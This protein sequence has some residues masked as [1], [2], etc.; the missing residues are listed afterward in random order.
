MFRTI[1]VPL[2]DS[3][4]AE[5]VLPWALSLA[6]RAGATLD[7]VRGHLLYALTQPSAAWAPFDP[8]AEAD[9]KQE[10]RAYLGAV[11]RRL[12]GAARV[13][14]TT[15]LVDGLEAEGILRRVREGRADL[16]V[17][18]THGRG[19]LGRFFLGSVADVLVRETSVPVLLV[20]PRGVAPDLLPGP[21]VANVLVPLDGSRLAEQVL[22]PAADLA[23]A[24]LA[25]C[26]L[27]RV[28]EP[29]GIATESA[30]LAAAR[31]AAALVYL[32]AVADRLRG[33]G[34]PVRARV[35]V[36]AH[37][38]RAILSE[39]RAL[40]GT[41]ITLAT[42]GRSGVPRLVLGSVA[43]QVIRTAPGPVLVYRPPTG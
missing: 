23:R 4:F 10:E 27:L 39:A 33:Q 24:L 38:A 25:P 13:S 9:T 30:S 8:A 17:M 16:V 36:T 3:P 12:A 22:S 18:A 40:E 29:S 11:A 37:P 28:L 31:T 19:P 2:D 1:V 43:D 21:A 20:R 6:Q 7:L 41:V 35:A 15:T 34:L 5:Q 42:H 32:E 14:V 26:T